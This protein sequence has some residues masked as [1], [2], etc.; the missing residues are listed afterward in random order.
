MTD[1]RQPRELPGSILRILASALFDEQTATR[2]LF[3]AIA[4]MQHECRAASG[5]HRLVRSAIRARHLAG[6]WRTATVCFFVG[7]GNR[8]FATGYLALNAAG[9]LLVSTAALMYGPIS[10]DWR[11]LRS[12]GVPDADIL[13]M[14]AMLVPQALAVTIPLSVLW[15]GCVG[16]RRASRHDE[17]PA[18][19]IAFARSILAF[20]AIASVATWIVLVFLV[21]EANQAYREQAFTFVSEQ[22]GTHSPRIAQPL[23][24]TAEMTIAEL[25]DARRQA[26]AVDGGASRGDSAR[27]SYYLHQKF[28]IALAPLVFGLVTIVLR[29][30]T[31]LV[32]HPL[33]R[34]LLLFSVMLFAYYVV[35]FQGRSL[36]LMQALPVWLGAWLPTM[37]FGSFAGAVG[38]RRVATVIRRG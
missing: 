12:H 31:P 6:F 19:L 32:R 15:L 18:S 24:G 10:R 11:S 29:R 16:H 23:K 9:F 27:F 14:L 21:P 22:A 36:A 3:P 37:V 34:G 2:F 35:M 20:S 30:R 4:D 25:L 1:S 28:T 8:R 13:A 26:V 5:R 33:T 7:S 17:K 38:A